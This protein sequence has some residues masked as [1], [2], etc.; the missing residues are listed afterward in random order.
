MQCF[1]AVQ[2]VRKFTKFWDKYIEFTKPVFDYIEACNDAELLNKINRRAYKTRHCCYR[3]F[4]M[5]RL[6]ST[7]LYLHRNSI[8]MLKYTYSTEQV[9]RRACSAYRDMAVMY[10]HLYD[11]IN[12]EASNEEILLEGSKV[13]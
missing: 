2:K 3:P 10:N 9:L 11:K 12:D 13:E 4:I 1:I 8:K 6:F 7:F 5:E